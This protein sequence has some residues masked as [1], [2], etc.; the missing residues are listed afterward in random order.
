M[1]QVLTQTCMEG[2]GLGEQSEVAG[3]CRGNT[4]TPHISIRLPSLHGATFAMIKQW[5]TNRAVITFENPDEVWWHTDL[6]D[7]LN[8]AALQPT[9][10]ACT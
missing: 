8:S 2:A 6:L 9:E 1:T 10:W 7:V 5:P 4:A 3:R